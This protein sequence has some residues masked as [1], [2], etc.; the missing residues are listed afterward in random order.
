MNPL[1]VLPALCLLALFGGCAV[2]DPASGYGDEDEDAAVEVDSTVPTFDLPV[3]EPDAGPVALDVG[4]PDPDA[5][6]FPIDPDAGTS[7]LDAGPITRP[8]VGFARDLGVV[9]PDRGVSTGAC[10]AQ[11]TCASCTA[12]LTCGWCALTARC[13]DGTATGPTG[14]ATCAQGWAWTASACTTVD[15]CNAATS[16]GACAAQAGCGWCGA[17]NRCVTANTARTGPAAGSCSAAWAGTVVAC[18]APPTDPCSVYSDCGSC[19]LAAACGWCRTGTGRCM[20]GTSTGPN[21]IYGTCTSWAYTRSQCGNPADP[22]STSTGCGRCTDRGSC[23]WCED[24]N[25]CHTG[26]SSGPTGRACRSSNWTWDNF[27]GICSPF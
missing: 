11:T 4:K 12:Q 13:L 2:Q 14:G 10:A 7:V 15:P 26:T 3:I 18:T 20:T 19:S 25:T 8:D 17:S 23:G 6:T 22:C 1:R 5:G 27:L 24:S 9:T 16:C 21:A